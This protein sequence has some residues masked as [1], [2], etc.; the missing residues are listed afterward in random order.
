M[1]GLGTGLIKSILCVVQR[2]SQTDTGRLAGRSFRNV[3]FS[4]SLSVGPL[5][6]KRRGREVFFFSDNVLLL[7]AYLYTKN[8]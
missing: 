5:R 8:S 6:E 1:L 3:D 7:H 2:K 4:L